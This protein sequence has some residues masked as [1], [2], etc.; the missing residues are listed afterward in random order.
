MSWFHTTIKLQRLLIRMMRGDVVP[1]G[2]LQSA[3]SDAHRYG[4]EGATR[5]EFAASLPFSYIWMGTQGGNVFPLFIHSLLCRFPEVCRNSFL[6]PHL[7][8]ASLFFL[9][10][11]IPQVRVY[12]IVHMSQPRTVN[13]LDSRVWSK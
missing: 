8:F 12:F 6:V 10:L 7:L 5:E 9:V 1:Q 4:G 13:V 2:S 3:K 11:S